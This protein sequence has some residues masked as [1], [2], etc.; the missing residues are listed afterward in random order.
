MLT[1]YQL[2]FWGHLEVVQEAF[3]LCRPSGVNERS[4]LGLTQIGATMARLSL[5]FCHLSRRLPMA[6][7]FSRRDVRAVARFHTMFTADTVVDLPIFRRMVERW[8]WSCWPV[9]ES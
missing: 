2:R 5:Y 8:S 1:E 4:K 6:S 7:Q 3:A 9:A